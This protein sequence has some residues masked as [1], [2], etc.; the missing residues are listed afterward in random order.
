MCMDV[1]QFPMIIPECMHRWYA[2]WH[3]DKLELNM[4][5]VAAR[6]VL[7]RIAPAPKSVGRSPGVPLVCAGRSRSVSCYAHCSTLLTPGAVGKRPH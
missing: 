6:T 4:S 3:P 2:R 1:M 7:S 5:T